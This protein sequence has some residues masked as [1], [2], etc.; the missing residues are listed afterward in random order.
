VKSDIVY[1]QN[2][3]VE[4]VERG[5]EKEGEEDYGEESFESGD[6]DR[7]QEGASRVEG[8]GDSHASHNGYEMS[9]DDR[10]R[11][12]LP[13][14]TTRSSVDA[15]RVMFHD[16][17]VVDGESNVPVEVATVT[18]NR[19]ARTAS[20][21]TSHG[22]QTVDSVS[23]TSVRPSTS[24]GH[25]DA[26]RHYEALFL[27]NRKVRLGSYEDLRV[28]VGVSQVNRCVRAVY[29]RE[30][31]MSRTLSTFF[32]GD[33]KWRV[34]ISVHLPLSLPICILLPTYS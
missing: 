17:R 33:L 27:S 29:Y 10:K 32:C 28:P 31:Y 25:G 5:G 11:G 26:A 6:D 7:V 1:D 20:E 4:N 21:D 9:D 12:L 22:D 13:A 3:A 19:R 18:E 23:E 34:I 14:P 8:Q 2:D 16:V 30:D 15:K 24:P